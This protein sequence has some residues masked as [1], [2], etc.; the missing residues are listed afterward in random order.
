MQMFNDYLHVSLPL[1]AFL[2]KIYKFNVI[3]LVINCYIFERILFLTF[4]DKNAIK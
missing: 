1:I 2:K 4:F 3:L